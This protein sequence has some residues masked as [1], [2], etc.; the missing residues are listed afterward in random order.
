MLRLIIIT[1]SL[2]ICVFPACAQSGRFFYDADGNPLGVS[3]TGDRY[4]MDNF[5]ESRDDDTGAVVAPKRRERIL[6]PSTDPFAE[7]AGSLLGD[8]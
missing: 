5:D 2:T 7:M 3:T 6:P 8:Q 4:S 1:A